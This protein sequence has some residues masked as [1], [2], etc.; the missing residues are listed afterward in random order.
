MRA[1]TSNTT[2]SEEKGACVAQLGKHPDLGFSLGHDQGH[3]MEPHIKL[4]T[5][6]R[7]CLRLPLTLP[8]P[9][10]HTLFLK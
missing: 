4:C 6:Y 2:R 7:V 5:Q 8:L 10:A 1:P 3:E 9:T